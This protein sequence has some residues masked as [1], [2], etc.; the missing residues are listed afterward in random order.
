M[1]GKA[2]K[3]EIYSPEGSFEVK[4]TIVAAWGTSLLC[5]EVVSTYVL[6][7]YKLNSITQSQ[8]LTENLLIILPYYKF[9]TWQRLRKAHFQRL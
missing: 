4:K 6:N 1:S 2:K 5:L 3:N 7:R 9:E 8:D